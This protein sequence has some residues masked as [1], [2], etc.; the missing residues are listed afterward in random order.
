MNASKVKL[1]ESNK[2]K[3]SPLTVCYLFKVVDGKIKSDIVAFATEDYEDIVATVKLNWP[4]VQQMVYDA[5][6][7]SVIVAL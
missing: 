7:D 5:R 6:G 2:N 1:R 3:S 4:T